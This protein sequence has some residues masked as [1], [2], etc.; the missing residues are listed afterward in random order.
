MIDIRYLFEN[1]FVNKFE[2]NYSKRIAANTLLTKA[3]RNDEFGRAI[4]YEFYF[5]S[6]NVSSDYIDSIK[7]KA[8]SNTIIVGTVSQ[9]GIDFTEAEFFDKLS[10]VIDPGIYLNP[11]LLSILLEL[12][13]NQLPKGMIGVPADLL[14][15]YSKECLQFLLGGKG[16]RYGKERSFES[17]PDGAILGRDV[18]VLFDAKA[19]KFGFNP[20]A[21]DLKRFQSYITDFNKKY[22]QFA[23]RVFSFVVVSG[24][25]DVGVD[26]LIERSREL[27]EMCQTSLSFMSSEELSKVVQVSI[28]NHSLVGSINWKKILSNPIP[29]CKMLVEQI[30]KIKKDR[31]L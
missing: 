18:T 13:H 27:Y 5:L 23:G 20:S 21:D 16:R 31:I 7:S 12:G 17:L 26:A 2:L 19:Y 28:E 24:H 9:N 3:S 25:F 14:E 30:D 6:E 22:E 10:T 29:S 1:F 15:T 11:D 4:D 8:S